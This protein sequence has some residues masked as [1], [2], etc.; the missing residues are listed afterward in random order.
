MTNTTLIVDKNAAWYKQ[1]WPWFLILLPGSVVIA[2]IV[3]LI[4]AANGADS[5]VVDDYYKKGLLIN[6]D[7][8]KIAHAKKIDL[9]GGLFIKDNTLQLEVD[10]KE[11]SIVL[12]PVL[13]MNFVHPSSAEKD[14]SITLLQV[15]K[16][17]ANK[18]KLLISEH[19]TSQQDTALVNKLSE[20]AWYVRLLPLD[21]AWQ[22]KG[23]INNSIKT[24]PLYAD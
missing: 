22:L 15:Q 18:S 19:Y 2:S 9:S 12:P 16:V 20:G 6:K 13:K 7:L 17:T 1:F 24:V 23:K 10:A 5:L 8:T 14:F 21:E 3:T 11:N 4:I